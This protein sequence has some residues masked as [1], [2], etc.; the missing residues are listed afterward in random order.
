MYTGKIT[1]MQ[2]SEK[3]S[4]CCILCSGAPAFGAKATHIYHCSYNKEG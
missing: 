2:L 3:V 4:K 1:V